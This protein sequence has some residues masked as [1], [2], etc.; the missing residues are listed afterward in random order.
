M[1][2]PYLL[3]IYHPVTTEYE[4]GFLD[5]NMLGATIVRAS[6]QVV[7][8]WPNMDAGADLVSKAIRV[9]RE[10]ISYMSPLRFF[11]GLPIELFAPCLNNCKAI[12]GNS[13]AGI[14]E[15]SYLGIPSVNI[16]SRQNGRER[17]NDVMDVPCETNQ[18]ADAIFKQYEHGNYAPSNLYGDGRAS[19]R[20][21]ETLKVHKVDIQKKLMY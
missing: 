18:I 6:M 16:G 10:N 13:S 8:I 2:Q 7:W 11:T 14:R 20:I 17:A 19:K 5:T 3:V 4:Q 1:R 15:S 21:L 12:V 9:F